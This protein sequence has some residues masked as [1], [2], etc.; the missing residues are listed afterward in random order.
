MSRK[1]EETDS[2]LLGGNTSS[3]SP[4]AVQAAPIAPHR[5]K[6]SPYSCIF[7]VEP[8]EA[9]P[10]L[11]LSPSVKH[12]LGYTADEI[13]AHN[14]SPFDI[15]HPEE[16]QQLEQFRDQVLTQD[17]VAG[18]LYARVRHAGGHYIFVA[19]SINVVYDAVCGTISEALID[20][21]EK[22]RAATATEVYVLSPGYQKIFEKQK[23]I[24]APV[25]GVQ[26]V[27]PFSR[28]DDQIT[29]KHD[30]VPKALQKRTFLILD[31]FSRNDT[32]AYI[33][34]NCL[35]RDPSRY[36]GVPFYDIIRESD[37]LKIRADIESGKQWAASC[38][39]GIEHSP[40]SYSTFT[41]ELAGESIEVQ[42]V[43][44]S[45]SDGVLFIIRRRTY[46]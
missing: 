23:W 4:S 28:P 44:A 32:I 14:Y 34:N 7:V 10:F 9:C 29:R 15:I 8:T 37:K 30:V 20:P 21:K 1:G 33:S 46:F 27:D 11:W 36:R 31:R 42:G 3:Q 45:Y 16:Y 2:S 43:C 26:I 13:I 12:V 22:L 35:I 41:L 24:I 39:N 18:L 5:Y 38:P 40:Y 25:A 6:P 17:M 19:I